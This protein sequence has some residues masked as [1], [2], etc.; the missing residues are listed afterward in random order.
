M[1]TERVDAVVRASRE[2]GGRTAGFFGGTAGAVN[3]ALCTCLLCESVEEVSVQVRPERKE[4]WRSLPSD[5]DPLRSAS[6]AKSSPFRRE[7]PARDKRLGRMLSRR[8]RVARGDLRHR[9]S[10]RVE[11]RYNSGARREREGS[12]EGRADP[13]LPPSDGV[14]RRTGTATSRPPDRNW[15]ARR[16][17][18][19]RCRSA[20]GGHGPDGRRGRRQPVS[21]DA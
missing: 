15:G 12:K 19:T 10:Y 9:T 4:S 3:G 11:P 2:R 17:R 20:R 1:R 18:R 21:A 6:R 13:A 14:A 7:G 8:T 16:L 5:A